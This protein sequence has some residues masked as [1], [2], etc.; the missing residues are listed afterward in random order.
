MA[1]R[2]D[3]E[4]S[5]YVDD[6]GVGG[7]IDF[8][9]SDIVA[10]LPYAQ[11]FGIG[12]EAMFP[13]WQDNPYLGRHVQ[14][15]ARPLYGQYLTQMPEWGAATPEQSFAQWMRG[16]AAV[17]TMPGIQAPGTFGGSATGGAPANWANII[18]V[19]RSLDPTYTGVAPTDRAKQRWTDVLTDPAQTAALT[20]MATYDPA[21]GSIFGRLRQNALERQQQQF[22]AGNPAATG[23]AWL[24]H[25]AASQSPFLAPQWRIPETPATPV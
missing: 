2:W 22:F 10:G 15:L 24:G 12:A 20:S 3:P 18:N 4:T 1:I 16:K 14:N 6:G 13:G 17:D 21:A 9:P 19:A 23:A 25:L 11:Q 5:S 7:V 8:D